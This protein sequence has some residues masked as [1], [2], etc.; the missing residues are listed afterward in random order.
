MHTGLAGNKHKTQF[1]TVKP[2]VCNGLRGGGLEI[3]DETTQHLHIDNVSRTNGHK[4]GRKTCNIL[5]KAFQEM[6]FDK[7]ARKCANET[8][9]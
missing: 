4:N 9:A 7:A 8:I 5:T 3:M 6:E 1:S 2:S